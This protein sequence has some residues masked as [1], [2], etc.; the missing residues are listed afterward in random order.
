MLAHSIGD[1]AIRE[2]A[3]RL[4]R[5]RVIARVAEWLGGDA[6]AYARAELTV[7][8]GV[9]YTTLRILAPA[10]KVD[11]T[12]EAFIADWMSKALQMV[13]ELPADEAPARD[14]S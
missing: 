6:H 4:M 1:P 3:I 11:E 2:I 10:G 14:Q 12:G 8:L 9:G 7:M 5:E 13:V